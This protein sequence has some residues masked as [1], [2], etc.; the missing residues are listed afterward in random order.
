MSLP[1]HF[2]FAVLDISDYGSR[3]GAVQRWLRTQMYDVVQEAMDRAGIPW[4]PHLVV[5]RGDG[6]VLLIPA[7][8]SKSIVAD[9]FMRTLQAGLRAHHLRSRDGAAMRMRLVLHAGEAGY[10]GRTWVGAELNMA[11]WLVDL[12]VLRQVLQA[13]PSEHLVVG[14][15]EL[16]FQTVVW[17]DSGFLDPRTYLPIM[18][19]V[20]DFYGR[21]WLHAPRYAEAGP[22]RELQAW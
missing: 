3:N 16:W 21:V 14:V 17:Q 18:V 19:Q 10:D 2:T 20:K 7:T 22:G 8:V 4:D 13:M 12:P 9:A 11:C 6:I 15:S 5:E 1:F